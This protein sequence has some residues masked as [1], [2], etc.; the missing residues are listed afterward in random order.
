[1]GAIV[2]VA[3]LLNTVAFTPLAMI[4]LAVVSVVPHH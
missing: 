4:A 3:V 2:L 1:M